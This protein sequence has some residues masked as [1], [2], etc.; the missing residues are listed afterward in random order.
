MYRGTL[1]YILFCLDAYSQYIYAIPLKDKTSV[2]VLQGFLSLFSTTGWPEAVYL[3]NETSFQKTAKLLIKTAPIK[4]Y[5]ST[6]YCQFQN[7]SENYI[8][9]FK[10]NLPQNTQ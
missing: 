4:V 3:D 1:S 10:K 5:Y 2:S 6:P 9:N 8:K 7:Y